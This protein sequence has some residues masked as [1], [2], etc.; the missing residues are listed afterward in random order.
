MC[1]CACAVWLQ[2]FAAVDH[3]IRRV[4]YQCL[5]DAEGV[6]TVFPADFHAD[7][8]KLITKIVLA[9]YDAWHESASANQVSAP[10]LLDFGMCSVSHVVSTTIITVLPTRSVF[11]L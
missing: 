9:H 3:V 2:L 6:A 7:L 11:S 1:P 5:T 8:K 4:L 10:R